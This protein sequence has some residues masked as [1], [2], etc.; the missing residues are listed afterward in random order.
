MI[1][2]DC[3][4]QCSFSIRAGEVNIDAQCQEVRGSSFLPSN[5]SP[6]VRGKSVVVGDV[7]V[8]ATIN[9]EL[10][11]NSEASLCSVMQ[12]CQAVFISQVHDG[13]I[14]RFQQQFRHL[15]AL[16]SNL[17]EVDC[18]TNKRKANGFPMECK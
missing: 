9:Q 6:E 10:H 16:V 17:H 11:Y 1:Q 5:Y 4:T 8:D 15:E 2:A 7:F 13:L 14:I 18:H 3:P 12:G